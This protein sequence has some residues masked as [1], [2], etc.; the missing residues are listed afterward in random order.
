M[1]LFQ[2]G[3]F[4]LHSGETSDF[5]I[6]CD[7]LTDDDLAT[8]ARFV[9]AR[10]RFGAVHG[11]PNGGNR[12]RCALAPLV[13][14][15]PLLIVDDVLTTGGSMVRAR[16]QFDGFFHDIIGVVVFARKKPAPWIHPMFQMWKKP[17]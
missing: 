14:Y 6:D 3:I 9:A 15:G 1:N 12:L 10:F 17:S 11:I 7:A 4:H 16:R 5:K 2:S 13:T 8:L